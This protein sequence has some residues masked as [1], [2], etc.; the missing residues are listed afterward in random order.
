M[1]RRWIASAGSRAVIAAAVALGVSY[2]LR[3]CVVSSLFSSERYVHK[4]IVLLPHPQL[5]VL[6]AQALDLALPDMDASCQSSSIRRAATRCRS[7]S[8][9]VC[10]KVRC[11]LQM[12]A[13]LA[14]GVLTWACAARGGLCEVI[15][16]VTAFTCTPTLFLRNHLNRSYVWLQST[17]VSAKSRVFYRS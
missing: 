14:L 10:V 17:R 8:K 6:L 11:H 1:A 7:L 16:I 2:I 13:L 5:A 12:H 9:R 3:P 4:W 15:Q